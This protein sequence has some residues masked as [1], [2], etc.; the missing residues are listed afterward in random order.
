LEQTQRSI[1][2]GV[3]HNDVI[4][5]SHGSWLIC[6]EDAFVDQATRLSQL[7]DAFQRNTRQ[8]LNVLEVPGSKLSLEEAVRTYLF[9]SQL[10]SRSDEAMHLV[11]PKQCSESVTVRAIIDSWLADPVIPIHGVSYVALSESMANGGGPAC[12]RLRW[13]LPER[14]VEGPMR[15]W[16]WTP[17]RSVEIQQ[18]IEK[19]YAEQLEFEDFQRLDFAEHAHATVTAFPV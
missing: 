19:Y 10:V 3:F 1:D 18:W 15:K 2:A 4:A 5:M 14:V 13:T 7:R 8:T 12:L 9:N 11:C 6:H 17:E 16:R